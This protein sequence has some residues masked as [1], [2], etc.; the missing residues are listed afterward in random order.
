MSVAPP[1]RLDSGPIVL[2][3]AFGTDSEGRSLCTVRVCHVVPVAPSTL[4]RESE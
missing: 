4:A 1:K 3:C 2:G